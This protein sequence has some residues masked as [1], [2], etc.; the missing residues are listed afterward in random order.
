M[1]ALDAVD[2]GEVTD[3]RDPPEARE[4]GR[5]GAILGLA[6]IA[7]I[8]LVSPGGYL[9]LLLTL[10]P[11]AS[12]PR[13]LVRWRSVYFRC[14]SRLILGLVGVRVTVCG[15]VPRPP[16]LLVANHLSYL[17]ILVLAANLPCIF[18]SKTEV[19]DW[20]LMGRIVRTLGTIFV[21]RSSRRDVPRVLA[22]ME[23]ALGRGLGVVLFPE[24]TSSRGATVEPFKSPL[25]ALAARLERP[26]HC[27][28]LGY[29]TRPG[30][31]PADL[32][33]CWWGK[34]PFLPHALR[35][36][37]LRG[38][39]ATITLAEEPIVE[40]DRKRLAE[41]LREAVLACF[42]PVVRE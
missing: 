40:P 18:V 15:P 34:V 4:Q 28:A 12:F 14:W 24:G 36:L 17:D 27:A 16:F 9:L 13:A 8:C 30:D 21:D 6:R 35:L 32:A 5:G 23:E 19:Q 37:R 38:G 11:L 7:A 2:A 42:E 26:V 1:D 22:Q 29:R 41:R 10:A 39:E 25:L 3:P 31:L 20:P 33:I